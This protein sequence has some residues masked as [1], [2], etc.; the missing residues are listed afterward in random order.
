MSRPTGRIHF[1]SSSERIPVDKGA[2]DNCPAAHVTVANIPSNLC[3][4]NQRTLY[5]GNSA[6][7]SFLQNIQELMQVEEELPA[8]SEDLSN[9]APFEEPT[10]HIRE[11]FSLY[12]CLDGP[13]L[14]SLVDVFFTST[15]GILDIFNRSHIQ[16]LVDCWVNRT[17]SGS[18]SNATI[19]Y[20]VIAYAAQTRSASEADKRISQ[21]CFHHGHQLAVLELTSEP[22]IESVQSFLLISLYMLGCSQRNGAH[23]N[24]GIALSAARALGYHRMH[25]EVEQKNELRKKVPAELR[26]LEYDSPQSVLGYEHQRYVLRNASVACDYHFSMMLL[27]RPFLVACL[28]IS[29]QNNTNPQS[30]EF[31]NYQNSNIHKDVAQGAMQA[32]DAALSTVQLIY[33]IYVAGLLFNNMPLVVA[34]VFVSALTVCAAFLGRLG[35]PKECELAIHRADQILQHFMKSSPQAKQYDAILKRLSKAAFGFGNHQGQRDS[36]NRITSISDLFGSYAG[37]HRASEAPHDTLATINSVAVDHPQGISF[38]RHAS[39]SRPSPQAD[40]MVPTEYETAII[41]SQ[42]E[43]I[44]RLDDFNLPGHQTTTDS[45][46]F[47]GISGYNFSLDL[48]TTE[49]IWDINWDGMLL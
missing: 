35:D 15:C 27:T 43:E 4:T 5:L 34:R 44:C 21:G 14:A 26:S 1:D 23:F 24:L 17:L 12:D 32:I 2:K 16:G 46:G 28:R 33:E 3:D 9:N 8:L 41:S 6:A 31:S 36:S 20:L 48:Q 49:S 38:S 45:F 37:D 19:L 29:F 40:P 7:L 22:S 42:A 25:A 18:S 13:G 11:S 30:G 39:T 10:S 47:T